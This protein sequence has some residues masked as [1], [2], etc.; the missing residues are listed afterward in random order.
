M[1]PESRR[2]Q[3]HLGL[4]LVRRS[5]RLAGRER[6]A[7]PEARRT[8]IVIA[9]ALGLVLAAGILLVSLAYASLTTD[10][11][12]I[13]LLPA[14]LNTK[15]GLLLQPTQI[16]DRSGQNLIYSLENPG[17][18]RRFL[19]LDPYNGNGLSGRTPVST[20]AG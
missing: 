1:L 13:A 14:L 5:R 2:R 19:P 12:P 8:F 9:A 3:Q 17:V 6:G 7:A 18:P 20:W 15:N 10:L 4:L 11:P 16:Y